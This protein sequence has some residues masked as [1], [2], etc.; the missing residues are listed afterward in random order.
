MWF[1][2]V[3]DLNPGGKDI[4]AHLIPALTD[5]YN[6][7]TSPQPTDDF[8][9]GMKFTNGEFV[10]DDGTVLALNI[11]VFT[12]GIFADT[13]S[14]SDDSE[15]VLEEALSGLPAFG[16]SYDPSMIRK[17]AYDSQLHVYCSRRLSTLN[18]K[19]A[20]LAAKLSTEG[21]STFDFS[22][23]EFWPD[24]TLVFKPPRFSFQ[25]KIGDAFA[26]NRYWS[27]APLPTDKHLQVLNELEELLS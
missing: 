14:S 6:F 26:E 3:N 27:Q 16:F 22:A 4:F 17:K 11:T 9:E 19:L 12:D 2:D 18:P 8:K 7:K 1:M 21:Q 15:R 5:V 23:I 10:K 24:Q 13:F 20:E 25:K